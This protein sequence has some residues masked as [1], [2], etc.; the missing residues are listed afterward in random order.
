MEV[1]EMDAKCFYLLHLSVD[2]ASLASAYLVFVNE[3]CDLSTL[4]S[5]R[6]GVKNI[7]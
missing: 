5:I 1:A 2:A 6:L 4:Q 3:Y 7:P